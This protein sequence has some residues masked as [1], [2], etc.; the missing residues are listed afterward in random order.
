V[1]ADSATPV[2]WNQGRGA[3]DVVVRPAAPIP[4]VRTAV[5]FERPRA[6]MIRSPVRP[7]SPNPQMRRAT[8]FDLAGA[9]GSEGASDQSCSWR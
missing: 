5:M 7:A 9:G 2:G 4:P 1:D 6:W 8:P 3:E